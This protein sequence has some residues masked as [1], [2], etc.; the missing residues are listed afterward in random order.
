MNCIKSGRHHS[1]NNQPKSTSNSEECE[2]D[3]SEPNDD[4]L[5]NNEDACA[6]SVDNNECD[7]SGS[8]LVVDDEQP[9]SSL[10]SSTEENRDELENHLSGTLQSTVA[11]VAAKIT[12]PAVGSD[13]YLYCDENFTN[14]NLIEEK[15]YED[16]CYVTFSTK[17]EVESQLN[18]RL[19]LQHPKF[20]IYIQHCSVVSWC[21]LF[22]FVQ[23]LLILEC[24]VHFHIHLIAFDSVLLGNFSAILFIHSN[25]S[26]IDLIPDKTS[27]W[28]NDFYFDSF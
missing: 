1:N 19:I 24:I 11:V 14:V 15:I 27:S 21:V 9:S 7:S 13:W 18:V 22:C 4:R 3:K 5:A 20:S 10:N 25:R 16:L 26:T 8:S 2:T 23:V 12:E 6:N 28:L 17:T